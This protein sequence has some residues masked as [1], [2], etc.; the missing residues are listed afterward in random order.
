MN[1]R[2]PLQAIQQVEFDLDL[3]PSE[4]LEDMPGDFAWF[5]GRRVWLF[6]PPLAIGRPRKRPRPCCDECQEA[7]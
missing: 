3:P 5:A 7:S 6:D 2:T 1:A 4:C